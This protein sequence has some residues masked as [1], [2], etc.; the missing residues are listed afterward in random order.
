MHFAIRY[1]TLMLNTLKELVHIAGAKVSA[2]SL[3]VLTD[4]SLQDY[5]NTR[6]FPFTNS[7]QLAFREPFFRNFRKRTLSDAQE[8]HLVHLH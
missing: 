1:L 5:Y 8:I 7:S 6:P 2:T 3:F 4:I